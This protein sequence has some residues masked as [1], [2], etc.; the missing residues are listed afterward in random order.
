MFPQGVAHQSGTVSPTAFRGLVGGV[1]QL[2]I[3]HDLYDFHM[4]NLLHSIV[5]I[6][7]HGKAAPSLLWMEIHSQRQTCR[8]TLDRADEGVRLYMGFAAY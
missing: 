6:E 8:A 7:R 4:W 5:H 2:F 1:Q 3:Q